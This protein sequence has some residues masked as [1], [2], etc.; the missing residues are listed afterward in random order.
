LSKDHVLHTTSGRSRI[1]NLHSNFMFESA[2]YYYQ[3]MQ[4]GF[5][6]CL[7]LCVAQIWDFNLGRSRHHDEKSALEVGY[8][9]NHGGFMI[10]SYSDMLKDISSGTTKD[11]EDIY[12]S[13]YCST[14][15]DIMSSNICQLSSKNVRSSFPSLFRT[16]KDA[17]LVC[18]VPIQ[19]MWG[20][21][22]CSNS[23]S[24]VSLTCSRPW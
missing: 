3:G 14:A 20:G 7:F 19:H 5:I 18:T 24:Y 17:C 21:V 12:D 9:S 22:H 13:R 4:G 8:G 15:E 16:L 23:V 10:K 1:L 6:A 2:Y 11:L